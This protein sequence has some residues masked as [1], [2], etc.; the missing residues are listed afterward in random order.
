MKIKNALTFG[1][2]LLTAGALIGSVP[3]ASA[4]IIGTLEISGANIEAIG[5]GAIAPATGNPITTI[6]FGFIGDPNAAAPDLVPGQGE[7]L[8]NSADG[9][10]SGFNP[11][12]QQAGRVRDLPADGSFAPVDNF[13]SFA[14]VLGSVEPATNPSTFTT[15]FDLATLSAPIYTA[16]ATGINANF[17]V[18]GTFTL[19]DGRVV[20][21]E[22]II[23]GE[24][25]FSSQPG[26]PFNDLESYLAYASV[27][28]N[29]VDIDSWSGNLNAVDVVEEI[30]EPMTAIG[31]LVSGMLAIKFIK[32][33]Q[34]S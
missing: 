24:I 29:V 6:D 12:P 34:Y 9:V 13:L 18:T 17:D 27:A 30:P 21:G 2:P 23:G 25:L 14:S 26:T 8:I 28:G 32:R 31:L 22:G 3:A 4:A 7:F 11:L 33:K 5:T 20:D 19:A 16:T 1:L 10:F 15:D